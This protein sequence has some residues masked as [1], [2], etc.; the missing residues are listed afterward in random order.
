[1]LSGVLYSCS[2]SGTTVVPAVPDLCCSFISVDGNALD[3]PGPS[4]FIPAAAGGSPVQFNLNSEIDRFS[5]TTSSMSQGIVEDNSGFLQYGSGGNWE[6]FY[7]E[8]QF[9]TSDA[10][11]LPFSDNVESLLSG[12]SYTGLGVRVHLRPG[13]CYILVLMELQHICGMGTQGDRSLL[14]A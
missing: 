8:G 1:M 9:S 13:T 10:G 12:P 5:G 14:D 7:G 11:A 4:T 2:A 6:M 3:M